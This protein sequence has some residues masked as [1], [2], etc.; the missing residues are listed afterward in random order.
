[1]ALR[2]LGATF[3]TRIGLMTERATRLMSRRNALRAAFVGGAASLAAISIGE[4]PALADDTDCAANCGPTPRCTGC[5]HYRCP[6]GYGKC[7]GSPTGNCFNNQGYRCEWPAGQW[8]ACTGIGEGH[9][10]KVCKDCIGPRGCPDWCTC[11]TH[12]YCC[13]CKTLEDFKREQQRIQLLGE[14]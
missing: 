4:T 12:C 3:D 13:N 8:I 9:G 7:R 2:R 11:L 5:L 14:Q 6:T 1:M 10:Y